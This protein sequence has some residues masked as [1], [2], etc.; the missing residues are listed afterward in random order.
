MFK[1]YVFVYLLECL[2]FHTVNQKTFY[3]GSVKDHKAPEG[4]VFCP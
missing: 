2:S 4:A 1:E 3:F